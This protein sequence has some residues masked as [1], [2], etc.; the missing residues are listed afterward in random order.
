MTGSDT[1]FFGIFALLIFVTV[2]LAEGVRRLFHWSSE[3]T[4]KIVHIFVGVLVATTPFVLNSMWPMVILG[5]LFAAIDFWAIR[6]GLFKGMHGTRRHTYGTVFYPISFVILTVTLWEHHKLILV[7]SMLIMAISDAVAAIVGERVKR[8]TILKFG[9]EKKS[10]Q[11][12]AAMFISTFLIVFV[13]CRVATDLQFYDIPMYKILWIAA[14]VAIIATL[15]EVISAQGSDNL[16]VPLSAAFTMFFMLTESSQEMIIFNLGLLLAILLAVISFRLRFLDSGGAVAL[17]LLGTLVFGVGK[18]SFTLPILTFFILSSLLSKL[19]K[20]RKEILLTIFE[21]SG[22]RDAFQVL[23]N[24]G[25]PA[26]SLLFWY[27]FKSDLFYL[28]YITSLAAVTA[29]T[30]GTEIGV[31]AKGKT[32]SINNFRPVPKGT[33]GGISGL[34]TLGAALGA[35]VLTA[36]GYLFSPHSSPRVLSLQDAAAIAIAGLLA[37][38]VDSYIGSTIQAQFL[39]P[40]CGKQTEKRF[41]CDNR[42]TQFVHGYKWINND[43]VN[44]FCALSGVLFILVYWFVRR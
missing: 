23:A 17:V 14:I 13:C 24:G 12:S 1:L 27:F 31:M 35:V 30:W 28:M 25:I 11:G 18:I 32:L 34:G 16:S 40:V 15:A 22:R 8:P 26:L 36:V 10:L 4:R 6:L 42:S 21:K 38:F 29:D 43:V 37:S 20:Q 2:A 41:H 19:G 9:P 5:I 44:G 33:S 3:T 7:A 39:C